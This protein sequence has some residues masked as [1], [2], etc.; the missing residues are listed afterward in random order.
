M[1][2]LQG[3]YRESG[4]GLQMNVGCPADSLPID[5]GNCPGGADAFLLG[6]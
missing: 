3:I 6:A 1:G 5:L 4:D 2:Y